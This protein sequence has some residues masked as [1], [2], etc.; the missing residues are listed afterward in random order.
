MTT[1][2]LSFNLNAAT[3]LGPNDPD[4]GPEGR[5][6]RGMAIAAQVRIDKNRLGYRVPS[7]SGNGSYVVNVD[8]DPSALARTLRSARNAASTFSQWT[9]SSSVRNGPMASP[10]RPRPCG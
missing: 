6:Q 3:A 7:Q 8:G 9:S 5:Q 10:S 4:D 1:Q 2:Q